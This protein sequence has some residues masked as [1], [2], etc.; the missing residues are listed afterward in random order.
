MDHT[1]I[2]YNLDS[3]DAALH[4]TLYDCANLPRKPCYP[5]DFT[6]KIH[7]KNEAMRVILVQ[8]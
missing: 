3:T 5:L 1:S 4:E 7:G 8:L 2:A 6:D